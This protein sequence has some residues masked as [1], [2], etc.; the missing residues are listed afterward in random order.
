MERRHDGYGEQRSR[1]P[2]DDNACPAESKF[3]PRQALR[4]VSGL[5]HDVDVEYRAEPD[6][7]GKDVQVADD[8]ADVPLERGQR[9]DCPASCARYFLPASV[10]LPPPEG[11]S[12]QKTHS[13]AVFSANSSVA[14][15]SGTG[16]H[17]K[18]SKKASRTCIFCPCA[19][20]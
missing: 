16:K 6:D 4:G 10:R 18:K 5:Q 9:P 14:F 2:D 8:Q 20:L 17:I 1:N 3:S 15:E 19:I 12:W 7:P 11:F 13:K